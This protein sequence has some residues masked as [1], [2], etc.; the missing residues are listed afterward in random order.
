MNV[1]FIY[2]KKG[3]I[4]KAGSGN[5]LFLQFKEDDCFVHTNKY[6]FYGIPNGII[7]NGKIITSLKDVMKFKN[8][9]DDDLVSNFEINGNVE[10]I[11]KK[12]RV[13][14]EIWSKLLK[15]RSTSFQN[16][17]IGRSD[18]NQQSVKFHFQ[19]DTNCLL[20]ITNEVKYFSDFYKCRNRKF[21]CVFQFS[22]SEKM[23][24][25][26]KTCVTLKEA[27]E[28]PKIIQINYGFGRNAP[29]LASQYEFLNGKVKNENFIFF[30][31][32]SYMVVKN[33]KV[34][35]S[36][37]THSHEL[38]SIAA[39]S[40][41]NGTH[42]QKCWV[43]SNS[44]EAAQTEIIAKFIKF[45]I[46][47]S[48]RMKVDQQ[49]SEALKKCENML[50]KKQ[51][52]DLSKTDFFS[53]FNYVKSL[54]KLSIIGYNSSKYDLCLIFKK[55]VSV[56]H[57]LTDDQNINIIKKGRK[58]FSVMMGRL[59][60]KDL[61][62]FTSPMTLDTYL[63]TWGNNSYK[64]AYP[65]EHFRSIEEIRA[66]QVFPDKKCFET[67]IGNELSD[68]IY[69]ESK[70]IYN[71]HHSRPLNDKFYWP[72]FEY[73]LIF[74]N[75]MDVQPVSLALL[76]QF[77][78]FEKNFNLYPMQYF[79]LPSY[80]RNI[81]YELY[82]KKLPHFFT[83]SD[84]NE[85]LADFRNNIIGGLTNVMLR[86]VSL[87]DESAATAAKVNKHGE[88]WKKICFWDINAQYPR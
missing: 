43:I 37:K 65:Y 85:A 72:N 50:H 73:Y 84:N 63:K 32:E 4:H 59:W 51:Y 33:E 76:N 13:R 28:K 21:G 39:N 66:C 15:Q 68:K 8:L 26:E 86:H 64:Y 23:L 77:T 25:H 42:K 69:E 41:V 57:K 18:Q 79:G 40:Y 54:N 61:L 34:G 20:L 19:P 1:L 24:E 22:Q 80:S 7:K 38:L 47:E 70:N 2:K 10:I 88:K 9:V 29:N 6:M 74:Y 71:S 82:D 30:D 27:S 46:S 11:E 67:I 31:C 12:L 56:Y 48:E 16:I 44:T 55:M 14:I 35:Q 36:V 3:K 5:Q 17:Y 75:L 81:M 53:I 87:G 78:I 62:N 58:Y 52:G 45:C 60:W 83:F 49:I